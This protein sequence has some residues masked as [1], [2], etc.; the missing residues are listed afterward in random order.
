MIRTCLAAA[1]LWSFSNLAAQDI[2]LS[3]ILPSASEW[4]AVE[5]LPN[6]LTKELFPREIEVEG[7]K[8]VTF[9]S[10][11]PG[12]K[13][14]VIPGE[15]GIFFHPGQGAPRKVDNSE[16]LVT[17]LALTPDK[18]TLLAGSARG[19]AIWA[20][21]VNNDGTLS[22]KDVYV[23]LRKPRSGMPGAVHSLLV[24]RTG[25]I[26]AATS[27]GIQVFDPTGR[28][29]GVLTHPAPFYPATSMAFSPEGDI[30]FAGL[31]KQA[32][33]REILLPKPMK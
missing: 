13:Y 28:L 22:G 16:D 17:A 4:K 24:D 14:F 29:C 27:L 10:K 15:P 12:E 25:R 31:G 8:F 26:F 5:G 33:Q 2:S 21:R 32:Y 23:G 30:L 1:C 19:N 6:G 20:Y 7:K 3:Q 11:K 9:A 18:G